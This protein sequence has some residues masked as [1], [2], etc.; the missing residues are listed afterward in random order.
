MFLITVP[1]ES[2]PIPCPMVDNVSYMTV[3]HQIFL[4]M[5][6]IDNFNSFAAHPSIKLQNRF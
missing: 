3:D 6:L 5:E 2:I 1:A 4:Y